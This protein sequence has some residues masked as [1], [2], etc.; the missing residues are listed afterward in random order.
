VLELEEPGRV[1]LDADSYEDELRLRRWLR[2]STAFRNLPALLERLLD[3]LD[4][5]DRMAA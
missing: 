1:I 2:R 3:D 4:E 5:L